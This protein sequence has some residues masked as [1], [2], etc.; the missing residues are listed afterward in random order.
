MHTHKKDCTFPRWLYYPLN[1]QSHACCLHAHCWVISEFL[2]DLLLDFI[3]SINVIYWQ[4]VI[5]FARALSW[6]SIACT[7]IARIE[8][9]ITSKAKGSRPYYIVITL[10][11][12]F[13]GANLFMTDHTS[14]DSRDFRPHEKIAHWALLPHAVPYLSLLNM[15]VEIMNLSVN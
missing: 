12:C 4:C 1:G 3:N 9:V 8:I 10:A 6:N 11:W 14:R 5:W 15:G 13:Q 7:L 2:W